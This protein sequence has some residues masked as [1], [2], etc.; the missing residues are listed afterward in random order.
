MPNPNLIS[1][2]FDF[3]FGQWRVSHRRLKERLVKC[4]DWEEFK[5]IS[6][7]RAVL[8]GSGNIE[9]NLL[10]FPSGPYR[11]I[12][13]RAFDVTAQTWAIWWLSANN[14]HQL[15]VPVVGTFE[16]GIGSFFAEDALNGEPILVRFLWLRTNT[17]SPR[18]EQAMSRDGGRTW[19]TNWTMDFEK[20]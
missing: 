14:P 6:E 8:G 19:E 18:W 17:E 16:D 10:E 3:E 4:D 11:A 1:H 20:L 7:T 5:G 13:V 15:D 2:D 9:D 12:A